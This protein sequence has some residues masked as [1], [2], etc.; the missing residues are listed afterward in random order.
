MGEKN[1]QRLSWVPNKEIGN[2][3]H[4]EWVALSLRDNPAVSTLLHEVQIVQLN[5]SIKKFLAFIKAQVL[6]KFPRATFNMRVFWE[7]LEK[8]MEEVMTNK[9]IPLVA[10]T[11]FVHDIEARIQRLWSLS[12]SQLNTFT[13]QSIA[14]SLWVEKWEFSNKTTGEKEAYYLSKILEGTLTPYIEWAT[15]WLKAVYIDKKTQTAKGVE[16][17]ASNH[18]NFRNEFAKSDLLYGLNISQM[19]TAIGQDGSRWDIT[20]EGMFSE[21]RHSI[22]KYYASIDPIFA[23]NTQDI[24]NTLEINRNFRIQNLSSIP[25]INTPNGKVPISMVLE[26]YR[27]ALVQFQGV[28]RETKEVK[29]RTESSGS[30]NSIKSALWGDSLQST[31]EHIPVDRLLEKMDQLSLSDMVKL[32]VQF[33]TIYP[34]IG[35]FISSANGLT[36]AVNGIDLDWTKMSH[37]NRGITALLSVLGVTLIGGLVIKGKNIAKLAKLVDKLA[38]VRDNFPGKCLALLEKAKNVEDHTINI[39]IQGLKK[40]LQLSG[41]PNALGTIKKLDAY[42]I[43]RLRNYRDS[44]GL[45]LNIWSNPDAKLSAA[46]LAAQWY[47]WAEI[48]KTS[49]TDASRLNRASHLINTQQALASGLLNMGAQYSFQLVGGVYVTGKIIEIT[50]DGMAKMRY[51]RKNA[52]REELVDI[53]ALLTPDGK[54]W[55]LPVQW[56][57]KAP[58]PKRSRELGAPSTIAQNNYA[59]A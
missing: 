14:N 47:K 22:F 2:I 58:R 37:L 7:K 25:P 43:D 57:I 50:P 56:G 6:D 1:I 26:S 38:V 11:K 16:M 31:F 4:P 30:M 12:E 8:M 18:S 24:R 49:L 51:H 27:S 20:T 33:S 59:I 15:A 5:E 17:S 35:D 36:S 40:A 3:R 29:E 46:R 55:I 9:A 32:F 42:L 45:P 52:V 28:E 54:I 34:G 23:S 39:W 53:Q 19:V 44:Q 10:K 21:I 13:A 41:W 48:G